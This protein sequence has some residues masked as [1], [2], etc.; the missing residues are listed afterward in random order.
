MNRRK[1]RKNKLT[2]EEELA[3]IGKKFYHFDLLL[4]LFESES[5][6]SSRL[7]L[8]LKNLKL[9]RLKKSKIFE[10]FVGICSVSSERWCEIINKMA[11]KQCIDKLDSNLDCRYTYQIE[12]FHTFKYNDNKYSEILCEIVDYKKDLF[13]NTMRYLKQDS[14]INDIK[15]I[16]PACHAIRTCRETKNKFKHECKSEYKHENDDDDDDDVNSDVTIVEK[17]N[18]DI[19]NVENRF[20]EIINENELQEAK[21]NIDT[22]IENMN[23]ECKLIRIH[24]NKDHENGKNKAY[25]CEKNCNKFESK[26]EKLHEDGYV[27][28]FYVVIRGVGMKLKLNAR[29]LASEVVDSTVFGIGLMWLGEKSYLAINYSTR[30]HFLVDYRTK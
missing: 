20:V 24:T 15:V 26:F 11:T 23:C 10:A 2:K 19:R 29:N 14:I 28:N 8:F 27:G 13:F 1:K 22:R 16:A 9:N 18:P 5:G 25:P 30:V 4:K 6:W 7:G 17:Y 3:N 12:W 21:E